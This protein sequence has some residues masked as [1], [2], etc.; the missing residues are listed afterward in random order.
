MKLNVKVP[1][2]IGI[3][4]LIAI[5]SVIIPMQI[6]M[7]NSI[8]A[9]HIEELSVRAETSAELIRVK[10]ETRLLQL[11]EMATRARVRGMDW[12]TIRPALYPD[13]PRLDVLDLA[14]VSFD[15]AYRYV[16]DNSF[17]QLN[18]R[19]YVLSALNGIP[20]I[21][22]VIISQVINK[23]VLMLCAPILANDN[24]GAPVLGVLMAREDGGKALSSLVNEIETRY[25]SSYAF[26][27]NF[28]G[29]YVAYPDSEMVL[30]QFNLL[31]EAENNPSYRS[32]AD[33]VT[34][35]ISE[36][37]GSGSYVKN[38][39]KYVCSYNEIEG[40]PW[41]LFVSM[42]EDEILAETQ[43]MFMLILTIG[44]FCLAGGIVISIFM[45]TNIARPV[46]KVAGNLQDIAQGEGDLTREITIKGHK[47]E[48]GDLA[49][50]FNLTLSNIRTMVKAIKDKVN[51]LTNTS[52]ELSENMAKTSRAVDQISSNFENMRELES[53]QEEEANKANKAVDSIKTSIDNMIEM[54]EE[55][56]TSIN[57]SSSA[58][59][60]MTA[61][62]QS[63]TRTLVENV[64]NVEVLTEASENGKSGVQMVAQAIQEIAHDSEGLLEINAVMENIAAQTNLLSMN[65]AIEAAHAG[66]SGKGFAVVAAEIRKLAESS[67]NQSKT[68]ADMLKKIKTSIDS[69]TKSSNEV[70]SRFD[71][72]DTGVKTVSAHELN[73]RN[74]ME[75]QEVGGR[76]ILE[77]IGRLREITVSVK[78]GSKEMANSGDDLVEQTNKFMA[79]SNQVVEGMN[80]IVT[81]A[82]S[83]IKIAVKTVDEMS[84]ENS[85]NFSSLKQETEKFKVTT[86]LEMK[87]L[88]VVDDDVTH[89]TST[90]AML[91]KNYEVITAKSG[92]EALS[93]FYRGLVPNLILLDLIMPDMDGW[94]TY[95]KI[96]AISNL[97]NVP[98]AFFT[99]SE[100]P[101]DRSRAE[102]MGAV[103]YISKPVR[104]GELLER[105]EKIVKM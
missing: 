96:K 14:L 2:L 75:E 86:G 68:T 87:K 1:L 91:D 82:M 36:K 67:S 88:L 55:Q 77:S 38:G 42:E 74:A 44:A 98:I 51:A 28:D 3:I 57:S 54:I 17:S 83:E 50:Y 71:A 94:V 64:K 27:I 19:E 90:K 79:I 104:K 25:Q 61:N 97:H 24:P 40:H 31:K 20:A 52:F 7:R 6:I 16:S 8:M 47:D 12:E 99:S 85:R 10:L 37:T 49:N 53:K 13:L 95:E 22:D 41:I 73:I 80:E 100:E 84:E 69:I 11:M 30:N 66:E 101:Q 18:H 63:V 35:A 65:A 92:T 72:I 58:I 60:E 70:L 23:P 9:S 89:L 33:M 62:I 76:Q 45:G 29:I 34:K 56:A 4:V 48:I 43:R 21:S 39:K 59:E 46:A 81:G 105:V 26:M 102:K 15:G 5:I 103:D 93:L 32:K 78:D